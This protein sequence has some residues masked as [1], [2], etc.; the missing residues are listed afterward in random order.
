MLAGII[1]IKS[2]ISRYYL[3]YYW[4]YIIQRT[5][6]VKR[7]NT[8]SR[9]S[10]NIYHHCIYSVGQKLMRYRKEHLLFKMFE[11]VI[12]CVRNR[13]ILL[14]KLYNLAA[15][16]KMILLSNV[17]E[18]RNEGNFSIYFKVAVFIT[19]DFISDA[20]LKNLSSSSSNATKSI[21]ILLTPKQCTT[22]T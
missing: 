2:G 5:D 16:I 22:V 11:N 21:E 9:C 17:S 20:F 7:M 19:S 15:K 10:W 1:S 4:I 6:H 13:N 14:P 12:V 8:P 3:L 18:T